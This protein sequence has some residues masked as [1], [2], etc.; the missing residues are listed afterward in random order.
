MPRPLIAGLL[1]A[2]LVLA[3]GLSGSIAEDK[4]NPPKPPLGGCCVPA[5]RR[6]RPAGR[7]HL[8]VLTGNRSRG[9]ELNQG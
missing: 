9:H 1:A 8:P 7:R 3:A 5:R 4:K 2:G 6:Y